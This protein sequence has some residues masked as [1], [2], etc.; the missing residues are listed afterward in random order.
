VR[1]A[2]GDLEDAAAGE[3]R[4][5]PFPQHDQIGLPARLLLVD[6]LVLAGAQRVVPDH[7]V[8]HDASRGWGVRRAG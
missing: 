2:A 5:D 8:G 3:Q 4:R 7:L 1:G 6:A